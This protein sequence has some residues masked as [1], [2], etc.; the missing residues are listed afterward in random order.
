LAVPYLG[1]IPI[2]PEIC[3]DSDEGL[4]F[5]IEH[6]NSAASEAFMQIVAQVEEFLKKKAKIEKILQSG[7][8]GGKK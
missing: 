6:P 1:R 5:I 8:G 3:R 4:P 2:D 7:K